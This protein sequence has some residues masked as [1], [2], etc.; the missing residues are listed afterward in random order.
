MSSKSDMASSDAGKP[1]PLTTLPE[2]SA[3]ATGG[4]RRL[5]V[6]DPCGDLR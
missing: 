6:E 1:A 2:R 3:A 5:P 4:V